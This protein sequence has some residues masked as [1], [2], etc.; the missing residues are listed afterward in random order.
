MFQGNLFSGRTQY[1]KPVILATQEVEI[2]RITIQG[3]QD[4]M[5]AQTSSQPM[6]GVV[7]TPV[8]PPMQGSTNRRRM[9][10]VA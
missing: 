10:H 5:F 3:Q 8:I 6:A 1:L 9:F 2:R 7:H 4:K